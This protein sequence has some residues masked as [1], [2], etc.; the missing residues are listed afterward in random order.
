MEIVA[1]Y[2]NA[3]CLKIKVFVQKFKDTASCQGDQ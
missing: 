1:Q 3:F 2:V